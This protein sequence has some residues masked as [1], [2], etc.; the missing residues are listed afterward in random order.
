[1]LKLPPD[2]DGY[3]DR[4]AMWAGKSLD[5]FAQET[6]IKDEDNGLKLSDLLSDLMHWCDRN[7]V[8]FE[9]EIN[10]ARGNYVAETLPEGGL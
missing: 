10:R 7:G 1:M 5:V 2:P 9:Y 6:R 8:D 3:N 4:R